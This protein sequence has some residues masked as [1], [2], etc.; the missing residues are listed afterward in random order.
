[1]IRPCHSLIW[2]CYE[3]NG[4]HFCIIG[5]LFWA[6][7]SFVIFLSSLRA[8]STNWPLSPKVLVGLTLRFF[9]Y[10][11]C[12]VKNVWWDKI[13]KK[14]HSPHRDESISTA[15]HK[16]KALWKKKQI[17]VLAKSSPSCPGFSQPHPRPHSLIRWKRRPAFDQSQMLTSW[18]I[19][20]G[21]MKY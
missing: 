4:T 11:F 3:P 12:G 6:W 9:P 2:W 16:A 17:F 7:I 14:S 18:Q 21:V 15:V 13:H 19:V 10:C 8:P 5:N 1:M 20:N